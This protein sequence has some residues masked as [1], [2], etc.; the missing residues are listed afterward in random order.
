MNKTTRTPRPTGITG[1]PT[2]GA[3]D[4]AATADAATKRAR[5]RKQKDTRVHHRDRKTG[6]LYC[7]ARRVKGIL[8]TMDGHKATCDECVAKRAAKG[9]TLDGTRASE[10][11]TSSTG[12]RS[13][14]ATGGAAIQLPTTGV[15]SL[16]LPTGEQRYVLVENGLLRAVLRAIWQLV[17]VPTD[18]PGHPHYQQVYGLLLGV[19]GLIAKAE[20]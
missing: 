11:T 2:D 17:D 20:G 12:T 10:V 14:A 3:A 15:S 8:S 19:P 18:H 9:I 5:A 6:N 13:T 16:G 7:G 1:E 4:G